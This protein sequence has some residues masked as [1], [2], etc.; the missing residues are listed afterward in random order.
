M[1]YNGTNWKNIKINKIKK[2]MIFINRFVEFFPDGIYDNL[3]LFWH[4]G[5][6]KVHMDGC[7]K[8]E[9]SMLSK[10]Y[11]GYL[12]KEKFYEYL[13]IGFDLIENLV[14]EEYFDIVFEAMLAEVIQDNG[15]RNAIGELLV[16]KHLLLYLRNY[17]IEDYMTMV[18]SFASL[19]TNQ[20]ITTDILRSEK[21]KKMKNY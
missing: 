10:D 11:E 1:S 19:E 2:G 16:L 9:L 15:D 6:C 8:F 18:T 3:L 14:L 13:E 21:F 7:S 12:P 4:E 17:D 20:K 5:I